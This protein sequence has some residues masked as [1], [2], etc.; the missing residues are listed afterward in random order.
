MIF[1][2]KGSDY[3][4]KMEFWWP[5]SSCRC[6]LVLITTDPKHIYIEGWWKWKD[7]PYCTIV[8]CL[9]LLLLLFFFVVLNESPSFK[10]KNKKKKKKKGDWVT[11]YSV[12]YRL[13][14][15]FLKRQLVALV[16]PS[17]SWLWFGWYFPI[18][19]Q[20]AVDLIFSA[21]NKIIINSHNWG[22][23]WISIKS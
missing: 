14:F 15:P 9:T 1:I 8:S 7:W 3:H 16:Y 20:S 5:C 18:I 13:N 6:G 4:C 12:F 10:L 19:G 11:F 2:L 17:L 23:L 21:S 22:K